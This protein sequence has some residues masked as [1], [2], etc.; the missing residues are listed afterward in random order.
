MENGWEAILF[1]LVDVVEVV[2]EA[3]AVAQIGSGKS[4]GS[5]TWK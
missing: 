4:G 5:S 2:E 1:P 3:E